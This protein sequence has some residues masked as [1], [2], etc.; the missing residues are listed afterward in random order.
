MP[1][2]HTLYPNSDEVGTGNARGQM[3]GKEGG[4]L[5]WD[6]SRMRKHQ[7]STAAP[8]PGAVE[9]GTVQEVGDAI[10]TP[11]GGTE[12]DR[13][14]ASAGG[15]SSVAACTTSG[16][17]DPLF[18]MPSEDFLSG[19]LAGMEKLS[20]AVAGGRKDE[21]E[22]GG[23]YGDPSVGSSSPGGGG[24][25]YGAVADGDDNSD[26]EVME[27]SD[28]ED[29]AEGDDANAAPEKGKGKSRLRKKEDDGFWLKVSVVLYFLP[30]RCC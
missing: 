28:I 4:L 18:T 20:F 23:E 24:V 12:Q 26:V 22:D 5:L 9:H 17:S 15:S 10:G 13:G 29:E 19:R 2:A 21:G 1:G 27:M 16:D 11:G 30:Q 8:V 3:E 7:A 25:G 6:A 14:Q